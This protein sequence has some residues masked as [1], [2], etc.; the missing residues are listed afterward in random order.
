MYCQP[1]FTR[2]KCRLQV[3]NITNCIIFINFRC[4]SN[5]CILQS[6]SMSDKINLIVKSNIRVMMTHL[7]Q[8]L[9]P[10]K[11]FVNFEPL[12]RLYQRVNNSIFNF[13]AVSWFFRWATQLCKAKFL[14]VKAYIKNILSF[15]K[16]LNNGKECFSIKV[17]FL[18]CLN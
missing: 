11:D 14:H 13:F 8:I 16:V 9:N 10:L 3:F 2:N 18:L 4:F 6:I 17:F 1:F 15:I 12:K 5:D 7:K